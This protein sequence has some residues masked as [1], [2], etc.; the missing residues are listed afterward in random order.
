MRLS[1]VPFQIPSFHARCLPSLA[2]A[3][4]FLLIV[5]C[6]GGADPEPGA[7][8]SS[9]E[10]PA[11]ASA[12]TPEESGQAES[13]GTSQ[14]VAPSASPAPGSVATAVPASGVATTVPGSGATP[15]VPGPTPAASDATPAAPG[16]TPV[17][18]PATPVPTEPAG[19]PGSP[20]MDRAALEAFYHALRGPAWDGR[21][22]WGTDAPI[23]EWAGVSLENGRVVGLD[24][25][26][27]K[28]IRA[29]CPL[30]S[31]TWVPSVSC[32]LR[33]PGLPGPFPRS[34]GS[35]LSWRNCVFPRTC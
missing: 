2:A 19:P 18:V 31:G 29:V 34:W 17:I 9:T 21:P 13:S 4:A 30:R 8:S 27:V 33:L 14:T 1:S 15:T 6:G 26:R 11:S 16:A 35:W 22:S 23:G 20:A 5:A 10:A 32:T 25:N 3:L 7:S 28:E 24:L 12:S